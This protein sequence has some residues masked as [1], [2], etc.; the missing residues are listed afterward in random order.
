MTTTNE[1]R[2]QVGTE[3]A[4]QEHSTTDTASIGA[5]SGLDKS[6]TRSE[7][8][9]RDFASLRAT[10]AARGYRLV[11]MFSTSSG[12]P[13]YYVSRWNLLRELPDLAAVEA[14][15]DRASAR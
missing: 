3:R 1:L 10:A 15:L 2:P 13:S 11:R 12:A 5:A 7:V 14:F 6:T 4:Q 9:Q 8:E